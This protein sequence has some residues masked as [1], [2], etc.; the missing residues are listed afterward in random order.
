MPERYHIVTRRPAWYLTSVLL[1]FFSGSPGVS[2]RGRSF[3]PFQRA[4]PASR[5]SARPDV[6]THRFAVAD[7]AVVEAHRVQHAVAVVRVVAPLGSEVGVRTVAD[8]EPVEVARHLADRG[9]VDE[10]ELV[11]DRRRVAVERRDLVHR[12]VVAL[13]HRS[14]AAVMACMPAV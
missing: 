7:A 12:Q 13:H 8:V 3:R 10:V 4:R 1:V 5:S 2:A 14:P 9:Q 6:R 11:V